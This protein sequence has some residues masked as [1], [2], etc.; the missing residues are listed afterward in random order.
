[1]P[2]SV[3]AKTIGRISLYRRL[4][5][6]L[7][8]EGVQSAFSHEL[9][10]MAGAT[11]AQVRRDIMAVGYSGSPV[12]GYEVDAL[13]EAIG[14]FLDAPEPEALALVGIGNLGRAIMAFFEARRPNLRIVA[15]FDRDPAKV[16]RVIHGCRCYGMESLE[17]VVECEGIRSGVI[18]A[19]AEGAQEAA[20]KLV[21]A[22]VTGLVNFAPV[23]LRLPESVFVENMD[24][25]TS[26]EKAAY[27]ARRGEVRKE[28]AR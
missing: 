15:A 3:S 7:R 20:D 17:E 18:T 14:R 2:G 12:R 11:P 4:L 16:G 23:P 10:A 22:G 27:F 13:I 19:P 24:L 26:L 21:A 5:A 1:M 9:A 28:V 6:T 8:A 25:T